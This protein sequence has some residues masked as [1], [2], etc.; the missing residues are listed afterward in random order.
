MFTGRGRD[1]RTRNRRRWRRDPMNP[2]TFG[3]QV[4]GKVATITL[5]RPERKNPLTFESY[6]ELRDMFRQL[7][8]GSDVKVVVLTGAGENFCSG[9]D[10]HDI[11]GP[12]VKMRESK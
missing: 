1:H 7:A 10:V 2:K 3:W 12:L 9:G 6:A 11:I 8:L 4:D 5:S